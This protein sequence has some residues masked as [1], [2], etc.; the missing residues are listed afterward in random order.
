MKT[1]FVLSAIILLFA[2]SHL[3]SQIPNSGFEVWDNMGTYLAPQDYITFDSYSAGIFYPVTRATDHY[4]L[5]VGSYSI[6]IESNPALLPNYTAYGVALQTHEAVSGGPRPYFPIT[7]HPTSFTGYFK[8]FPQ[9]N[10]TMY[11]AIMLFKSGIRVS[12]TT[13]SAAGTVSDW[14]SFN[15][16]FPGYASADSGAIVLAAYNAS[17]PPPQYVPRGNSVL[18]VDNLNFDTLINSTNELTG[19]RISRT[20]F[21]PDPA[22]DKIYFDLSGAGFRQNPTTISIVNSA[23]GIVFHDLFTDGENSID[24]SRILPGIYLIILENKHE[25]IAHKFIKIE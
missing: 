16:P 22:R 1:K 21:Y 8:Y 4:P 25:R 23:G 6:R 15:L 10:D 5:S 24:I 20:L 19:N 3:F 12:G 2:A 9:K 17:G 13:L 14:T 7:G 18:Y 11:I